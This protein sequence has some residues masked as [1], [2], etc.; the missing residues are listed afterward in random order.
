MAPK[1][2]NVASGNA[3][4][5]VGDLSPEGPSMYV[6]VCIHCYASI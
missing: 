6:Y 4:R 2:F 5:V 3:A 1:A